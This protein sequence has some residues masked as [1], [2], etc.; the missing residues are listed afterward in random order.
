[1]TDNTPRPRDVI[2]YGQS[3]PIHPFPS[4]DPPFMA[5]CSYWRISHRRM[6]RLLVLWTKSARGVSR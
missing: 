6:W 1:V 3:R 2:V 4:I 5:D